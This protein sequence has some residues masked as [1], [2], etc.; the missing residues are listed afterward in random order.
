[1]VKRPRND[2]HRRTILRNLLDNANESR[3]C[4]SRIHRLPVEYMDN[5]LFHSFAF[6]VSA[7]VRTTIRYPLRF[8]MLRQPSLMNAN[9]NTPIVAMDRTAFI[10]A[11]RSRLLR[12]IS[13]CRSWKCQ[14][15]CQSRRLRT[16]DHPVCA[17]LAGLEIGHMGL[18]M[19]RLLGA[20]FALGRAF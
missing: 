15:T 14:R 12:S 5:A 2:H 13:R 4:R 3:H 16:N 7:L 17:S 10:K 6:D 1:L 8:W 9:W 19:M 11:K 18:S 20:M